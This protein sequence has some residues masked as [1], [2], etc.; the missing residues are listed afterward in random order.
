[1]FRLIL[2]TQGRLEGFSVL[3]HLLSPKVKSTLLSTNDLK[4]A[5]SN[6][7]SSLT[8]SSPTSC[9]QQ[10]PLF[11]RAKRRDD[12]TDSS[13]GIEEEEKENNEKDPDV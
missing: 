3:S 8:K 11:H 2:Q 10:I 1:M 5:L 6:D 9:Q 4:C 13:G 7:I 12:T